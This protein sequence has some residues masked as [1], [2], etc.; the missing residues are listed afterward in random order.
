[1]L[2]FLVYSLIPG[3]QLCIGLPPWIV[4]KFDLSYPDR[5]QI[6]I[7]AVLCR[8]HPQGKSQ[9]LILSECR[10]ELPNDR[11]LLPTSLCNPHYHVRQLRSNFKGR[12]RGPR[13]ALTSHLHQSHLFC[14]MQHGENR[15]MVTL[16]CCVSCRSS[17]TVLLV[18][19]CSS[20]KKYA[21]YF[22]MST[23]TRQH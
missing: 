15:L 2:T 1:M 11:Y 4:A 7:Q 14:R 23:F 13:L 21:N 18:K 8:K 3:L 5:Q 17:S 6:M 16:E 9:V 19:L 12:P 10:F 22:L 20:R